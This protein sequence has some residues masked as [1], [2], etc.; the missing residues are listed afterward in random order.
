MP[1]QTSQLRGVTYEDNCKKWRAEFKY[2]HPDTGKRTKRGL[3]SHATDVAAGE[4]RD[5]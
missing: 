5:K 1:S 2:K 3:G 4:A